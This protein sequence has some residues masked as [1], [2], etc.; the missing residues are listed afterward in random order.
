MED[1]LSEPGQT[2]S[3]KFDIAG[4]YNYRCAPHAGAGMIGEITVK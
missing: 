2:F 1:L 4:S 3:F